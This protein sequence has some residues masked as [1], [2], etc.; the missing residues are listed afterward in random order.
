MWQGTNHRAACLSFVWVIIGTLAIPMFSARAQD[1]ANLVAAKPR[2]IISCGGGGWKSVRRPL[3]ARHG[4]FDPLRKRGR[5]VPVAQDRRRAMRCDDDP[6]E[7]FHDDRIE[8]AAR[9]ETVQ[10]A[11]LIEAAQMH[12]PFDYFVARAEC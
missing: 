10:R 8:F 12:R 5:G 9:R 7:L 1:D 11:P 6:G 2:L 4:F 3:K